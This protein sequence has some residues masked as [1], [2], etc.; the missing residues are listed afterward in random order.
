M[1]DKIINYPNF[2]SSLFGLRLRH[3]P[4]PTERTPPP[5]ALPADHF[6]Y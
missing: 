2:R 3:R 4:S 1:M 5:P 6:K